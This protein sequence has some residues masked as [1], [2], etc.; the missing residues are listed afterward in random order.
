M[1]VGKTLFSQV[2]EFVPW[3]SF[4]RIVDRYNG[5]AGVRKMSCAEQFRVMAFAQLTWRESTRTHRQRMYCQWH[6]A[7]VSSVS[8]F[9]SL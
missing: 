5:N 8:T 2:M 9:N 6:E 1:H 4:G 7:N 3:T